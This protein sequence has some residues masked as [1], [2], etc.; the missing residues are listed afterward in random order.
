[1]THTF[2]HHDSDQPMPKMTSSIPDTLAQ[3][4]DH[5]HLGG[6]LLDASMAPRLDLADAYR[7]QHA[8]TTRRISRGA[9][10]IGWKLGYTSAAMRIQMGVHQPNYGPLLDTML[11]ND[12]RLPAANRRFIQPRVEPEIAIVMGADD[13]PIRAH[14]ALEVVDSV[15]RDYQFTLELNTADGSSA[16]GLV[17]GPPL[18]MAALTHMPVSLIKNGL[19]VAE[20][21]SDAA[22]GHPLAAIEWLMN[23]LSRRDEHLRPGD[24][25][26][27]GGL[28]HAVTLHAEDT[29]HAVFNAD[30]DME[31][32]GQATR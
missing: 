19:P 15:W 8:L 16:A 30:V 20:A 11:I 1:V 28:T 25:V 24:V 3:D 17:L 29:V 5:A 21:S 13:Q 14:A 12:Q 23:Q 4:I 27:T 22:M 18:P 7:T 26:L 10:P 6:H 2:Q 9:R 32:S 31:I